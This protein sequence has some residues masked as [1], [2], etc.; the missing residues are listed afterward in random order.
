MNNSTPTT[1]G[2]TV[3]YSFAEMKGTKL[4]C[5]YGFAMKGYVG[6]W[7]LAWL[8]HNSVHK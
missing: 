2:I 6:E 7:C 4:D 8:T 1:L 3:K 5:M